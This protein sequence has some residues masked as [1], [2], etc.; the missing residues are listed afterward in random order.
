MLGYKQRIFYFVMVLI[1]TDTLLYGTIV[2]LIP[3]YTQQLQL[4]PVM[5]GVIF[6]AYSLGLLVFSIPLGIIAERYGYRKVF[7]AGM[8]GL[9]LATALYGFANSPEILFCCRLIQGI[10][11]AASWTA[12]LAMV[13]LLYPE[14][15]GEKLGLIM[16][17]MG[18]GT[19]LGPP[20][21]GMLFHYLGYREMFMT[22]AAFCFSLL[23]MLCF[24][25][26][27]HLAGGNRDKNFAIWQV[28]DNPG[29]VWLGVVVIIASSSFGMLEILLPNYLHGRFGLGSLQIGMVFG[30]MGLVHAFSDAGVGFLSDRHGYK[31]FVYW[32]LWASA[33]CLPFL[34]LAPNPVI[35]T[36]L[37]TLLGIA[38]G[39]V[40]TP[41]QPLMYHIVAADPVLWPG[42]GAGLVYGVF[43]TCFSMGLM[44]GPP[45]GGMLERYLGF[46]AGLIIFA[47]LLM[48]SAVLFRYKVSTLPL[49]NAV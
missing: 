4:N 9:T 49:R 46:S 1:F 28:R 34:A 32:G 39:A 14:Q 48:A 2:P 20:I 5:M 10:A 27:G 22:L 37:I 18:L 19:I 13:A 31:P 30:L 25:K 45:L 44:L 43:N 33:L 17:A 3:V 15:Q 16:A 6:A 47:V 11:A 8:A 7:L 35:L 21:G 40:L 42:G 24:V 38:L 36:L 12:G 23:L 29:L 41:S 26:F